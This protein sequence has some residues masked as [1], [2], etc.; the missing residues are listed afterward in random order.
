MDG[1]WQA[2]VLAMV[3]ELEA[4]IKEARQQIEA[5]QAAESQKRAQEKLG[6]EEAIRQQY[7]ASQ[8]ES[9]A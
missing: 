9:L 2:D 4:E 1:P 3:E 8:K 5:E 6:R 7:Q